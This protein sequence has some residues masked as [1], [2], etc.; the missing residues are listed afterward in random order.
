MNVVIDTN[1]LVSSLWSRN[2]TCSKILYKVLNYD[3][4]IL[5]DQRII[6]EYKMVLERPKFR[7]TKEEVKSLID[8][9]RIEGLCIVPNPL[10]I[11][12]I[13]ESDKKFYEV[14]KYMKCPLITGNKKH[15][16]DEDGI[17]SPVEFLERYK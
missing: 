7:F 14:A 9:I 4:T 5:Y 6:S 13:D 1:V 2:G 3:L 17:L 10:N 8:F 16:P 15:F 11:E 12:F